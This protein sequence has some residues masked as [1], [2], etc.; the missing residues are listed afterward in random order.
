MRSR[1]SRQFESE[2]EKSQADLAA[3]QQRIKAQIL[4]HKQR[5]ALARRAEEKDAR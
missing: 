2:I 5:E 4:K 1:D 3:L